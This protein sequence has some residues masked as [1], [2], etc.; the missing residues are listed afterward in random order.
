MIRY[1]PDQTKPDNIR[2]DYAIPDQIR[3]DQIGPDQTKPDKIKLDHT[4]PDQTSQHQT[5]SY[6][7]IP[8]QTRSDGTIR[9][10]TKQDVITFCLFYE[11]LSEH[12]LLLSKSKT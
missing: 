1:Q 11:L 4:I 2:L 12:L 8:N 5:R 7:T 10:Q 9:Y 3:Q 6:D